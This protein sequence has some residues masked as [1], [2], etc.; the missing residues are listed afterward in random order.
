MVSSAVDLVRT[1]P[2]ADT[3][4]DSA[5]ALTVSGKSAIDHHVMFTEREVHHFDPS[6]QAF[7][8]PCHCL[9]APGCL[10]FL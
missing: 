6:F 8:N 9:F 4:S 7:D 10:V 5:A 2:V 1:S 3:L